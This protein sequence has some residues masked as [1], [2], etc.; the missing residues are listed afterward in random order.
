MAYFCQPL[1]RE[2]RQPLHVDLGVQGLDVL[3]A[4]PWIWVFRR[5]IPWLD[6][7]LSK[8][9]KIFSNAKILIITLVL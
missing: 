2:V 4:E 7:R 3:A 1:C 6:S 9:L 8:T 5:L